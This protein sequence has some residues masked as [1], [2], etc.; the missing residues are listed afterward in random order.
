MVPLMPC[1]TIAQ[2]AGALSAAMLGMTQA[3]IGPNSSG[4]GTLVNG[5]PSDTCGFPLKTFVLMAT[6][7]PA[8]R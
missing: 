7:A 2:V 5:S 6:L 3:G 4:T 8:T 1:T